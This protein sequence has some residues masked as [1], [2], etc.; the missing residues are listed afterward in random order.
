MFRKLL[1][2]ALLITS[3]SL[4][5]E[6]EKKDVSIDIDKVSEALGHLLVKQLNNPV[7]TFNMDKIVSGMKDGLAGKKSP[8][9]EEEYEAQVF[10][11]QEKIFKSTADKNLSEALKF[12]EKNGKE[13]GVITVTPQLQYKVTKKGD[14]EQVMSDSC[15]MIHY[16]GKLI[17]GTVFASSR[18]TNT[19]LTFSLKETIAGFSKGLVGMKKGEQRTLYIHPDLGYGLSSHLPPN[20]LLIFEVEIVEANK[21]QDKDPLAAPKAA[22]AMIPKS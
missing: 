10:A 7:I 6:E 20:S 5:A 3:V 2:L 11:I 21:I 19:P 1:T 4:F 9:T 17:D 18:E 14:G 15:P 16:T 22:S 12:L 8:L 13:T